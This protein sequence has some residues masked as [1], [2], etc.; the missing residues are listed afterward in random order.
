MDSSVQIKAIKF[1]KAATLCFSSVFPSRC[2]KRCRRQES[3][4]RESGCPFSQFRSPYLSAPSSNLSDNSRITDQGSKSYL[5][6]ALR[7]SLTAPVSNFSCL[8]LF[9]LFMTP[10][11]NWFC[12]LTIG[13][14]FW[15]LEISLSDLACL[16]RCIPNSIPCVGCQRQG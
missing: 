2:W 8:F 1:H 3:R 16:D 13:F 4:Y 6:L 15:C 14:L 11:P 10:D 9:F 7:L 12:Q 5:P